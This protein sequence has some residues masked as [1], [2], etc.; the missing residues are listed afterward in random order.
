M[1]NLNINNNHDHS[2]NDDNDVV[3]IKT[4]YPDDLDS[5]AICHHSLTVHADGSSP[6]YGSPVPV[7]NNLTLSNLLSNSHPSCTHRYH[8]ECIGSWLKMRRNCPLCRAPWKTVKTPVVLNRCRSR[9]YT[10][11]PNSFLLR[12]E[13][14]ME[15]EPEVIDL[16]N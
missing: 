2:I 3:Y 8:A 6:L 15:D 4:V 16:V 11:Q 9:I 12:M 5:C 13:A 7:A 1:A 14:A 10:P